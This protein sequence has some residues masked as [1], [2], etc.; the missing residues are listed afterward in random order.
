MSV[1]PGISISIG[2]SV[3]RYQESRPT[4]CAGD[5]PHTAV[6]VHDAAPVVPYFGEGVGH[7]QGLLS[8]VLKDVD[9]PT[10]GVK[11]TLSRLTHHEPLG[12][13]PGAFITGKVV[14]V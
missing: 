4:R 11:V 8:E 10:Q 7:G 2:I 6:L 3:S 13:R 12:T 5:P 1:I 14:P 9:G